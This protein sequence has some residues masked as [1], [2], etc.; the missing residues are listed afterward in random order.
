MKT[1][2]YIIRMYDILDKKKKLCYTGSL[3][4]DIAWTMHNYEIVS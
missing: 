3:E 4:C 1:I 2:C